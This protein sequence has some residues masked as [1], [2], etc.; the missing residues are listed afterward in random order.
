LEQYLRDVLLPGV[1]VSVD[2]TWAG[3][4]AFGPNNEKDP[5]LAQHKPGLWS[6]VRLGGMG[7]ALAPVLGEELAVGLMGE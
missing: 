4:M 3:T 6:A 5:L 7:V 2:Q 1:P